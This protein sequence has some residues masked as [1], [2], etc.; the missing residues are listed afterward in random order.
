V[1]A[2]SRPAGGQPIQATANRVLWE[3]A[4]WP[5]ADPV[6]PQTQADSGEDWFYSIAAS[7]GSLHWHDREDATGERAATFELL[8]ALSEP[9][10]THSVPTGHSP[11]AEAALEV[12][13]LAALRR[14]E[15]ARSRDLVGLAGAVESAEVQ[16]RLSVLGAFLDAQSGDYGAAAA[17]LQTAAVATS[18]EEEASGLL[19][20]SRSFEARAL[21]LLRSQA[22][23]QLVSTST[24]GVV[25]DVLLRV[26]PNPARARAQVSV[27]VDEPAHVRVVIHDVLGRL[28]A[29]VAEH[30]I[31]IGSHSW[32]VNVAQMPTGVYVV[33]ATVQMGAQTVIRTARATIVR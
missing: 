13:A 14:E 33:R 7:L 24:T 10:R 4:T 19:A 17:T 22:P 32:D 30:D 18:S 5:G 3:L 29:R 26:T 20:V 15:Y 25:R 12:R 27:V 2:G 11:A 21:S 23:A 8:A 6:D 28:I 9:L 1:T 16:R 31:S